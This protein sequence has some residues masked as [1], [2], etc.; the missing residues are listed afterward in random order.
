MGRI[1]ELDGLRAIAI[2]L[3]LAAHF[4]PHDRLLANVLGLGWCGVDLFFAISGFLITDILLALRKTE[5]PFRTFYWRRTLRIFPPYY[6]ILALIVLLAFLHA[7]PV[8]YREVA[9]HA[10]FLSS[11]T[12]GLLKVAFARLACHV[13]AP[14]QLAPKQGGYSLLQ[15]K[16]CLGI[17]WS[18]SVEE[19]FYLTWAPIVLKGSRRAILF[20][21]VAALLVCPLLRGLA[22]STPF[23]DESIGFVFRFDSLAAGGCV[24]LLFAGVDHGL[25]QSRSAARWLIAVMIVAGTGLFGLAEICGVFHGV[26]VRTRLGFSIW[27]FSLLAILCA[28]I[29]GACARWSGTLGPL[30]SILRSTGAANLG[31]VSYMMYLIHLPTYVVIQLLF[32]KLFGRNALVTSTG[33]QA[34]CGIAATAGTIGFA[35]LSWSYFEGPIM[36]MRNVAFPMLRTDRDLPVPRTIDQSA[37]VCA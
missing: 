25:V 31:K 33:L 30:S 23:V 13:S 14:L 37:R 34:L 8:N 16:D 7:E 22:H 21:S 36:R 9:R 10:L 6:L 18:L 4:A 2:L 26:D 27:G 20:C 15:F 32:V 28:S 24:A 19:L 1:Q 29:V 5:A 35:R 11:A 17:Y 12:P 3:V